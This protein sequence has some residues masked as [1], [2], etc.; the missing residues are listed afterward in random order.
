[1]SVVLAVDMMQNM[2][3]PAVWIL[4]APASVI[5]KVSRLATYPDAIAW[6]W[7]IMAA[8]M[9]PYLI[10]Q[11]AGY[12]SRVST[13]LACLGLSGGGALWFF[14]AWLGRN[15][16][17]TSLVGLFLFNCAVSVA[18]AAVLAASINNSQKLAAGFTT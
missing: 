4:T 7:L 14:L 8:L 11:V 13:R 12:T 10:A 1:M 9:I 3:S 2:I 16:D 15:L 17:Y 18:M 6:L 5:A